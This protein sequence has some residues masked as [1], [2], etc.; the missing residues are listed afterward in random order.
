MEILIEMKNKFN[1]CKWIC[2]GFFKDLYRLLVVL[3]VAW[4]NKL[5]IV[6]NIAKIKEANYWACCKKSGCCRSLKITKVRST[7]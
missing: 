7:N 5:L 2:G 1:R 3:F 6:G 4:L